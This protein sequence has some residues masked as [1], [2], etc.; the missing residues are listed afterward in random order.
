MP[1]APLSPAVRPPLT[2]DVSPL[3]DINHQLLM[4]LMEIIPERIY[5]KDRESRFIAANK[6][7]LQYFGMEM[8]SQLLGK[9]TFDIL[10]HD[11]AQKTRNDDLRT[12]ESGEPMVGDVE[13]KTFPDGRMSW[14]ST[15]KA[16]L[17]DHL[18]E[19][20][21][22]C[23]I[24]RDVTAAHEQAERLQ[25]YAEALAEKQSQMEGELELA[26]QVQ[27]ALLPSR[28]PLFPPT[29]TEEGSALGFSYRYQPM[30]KVGGDFFTVIPI[31]SRQAGVFICDVMGHGVHAALITAMQRTLVDDLLPVASDPGAFLS[32]A[33][34]RLHPFFDRMRTPIY[35][36]G[37]YATID[38]ETGRVRFASA[39]H[40]APLV[41]SKDGGV[42]LLGC[43]RKVPSSVPL[44]FID[45]SSYVVIEDTIEPGDRLLFYTDGLRDLGDEAEIGLNDAMFL[46]LVEKCPAGPGFLDAVLAAA[47]ESAKV[48]TFLDDVCLVEVAFRGRLRPAPGAEAILSSGPYGL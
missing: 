5:F 14:A 20:I 19:I 4:A 2:G 47:K 22:I 16:P 3:A 25:E 29:A 7:L 21:G 38:S 46:S 36:T 41:L 28:Y 10:Q 24:S 1:P 17:R 39:S 30:G 31:G 9:T 27:R 43:P 6:A 33:N 45:D 42:R 48:D 37:L 34:R 44:G 23:G 12:M 18:G 26:R 8:A 35:V 15:T 32:E 13:Q 11:A 40:P